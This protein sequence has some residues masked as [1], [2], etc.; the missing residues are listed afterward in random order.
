MY[1]DLPPAT[2]CPGNKRGRHLSSVLVPMGQVAVG[3]VTIICAN[4]HAVRRFPVEG[5][6][7]QMDDLTEAEIEALFPSD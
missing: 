4:C 5:P 6:L 2:P 3:W 1:Q 7:A